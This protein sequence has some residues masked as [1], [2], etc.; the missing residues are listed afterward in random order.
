[1]K[2]RVRIR[3]GLLRTRITILQPVT[4]ASGIQTWNTAASTVATVRGAVETLQGAEQA[5]GL[6][7]PNI[8][9]SMVTIRHPKNSFTLQA[10]MRLA[11]D[12]RLLEI[13]SV[14]PYQR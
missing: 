14:D 9:M 10:K 13:D 6:E 11:F 5:H 12:G 4:S 7:P 3:S 1:M 8:R 2:D